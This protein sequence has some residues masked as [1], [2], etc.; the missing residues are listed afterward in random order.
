MVDYA[1]WLRNNSHGECYA[2]YRCGYRK[3][4]AYNPRK[5]GVCPLCNKWRLRK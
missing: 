4:P 2:E 1:V 5:R 3:A